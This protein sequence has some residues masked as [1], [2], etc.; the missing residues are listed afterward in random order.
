M[1]W[2]RVNYR[3]DVL[4]KIDGWFVGSNVAKFQQTAEPETCR[5]TAVT[6]LYHT[7]PH[8]GLHAARV[9]C[10]VRVNALST[11]MQWRWY[12]A[13]YQTYVTL[14]KTVN[15]I[16]SFTVITQTWLNL[17]YPHL[18]QPS[19]RIDRGCKIQRWTPRSVSQVDTVLTASVCDY[20]VTTLHWHSLDDATTTF[21]RP[22]TRLLLHFVI[23]YLLTY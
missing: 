18:V 16:W 7:A 6:T 14:R 20:S 10:L 9:C 19:Y 21:C 13:R 1:E 17:E 15:A 12:S 3:C 23:T 5:V 11:A 4:E 2:R 22:R 8:T